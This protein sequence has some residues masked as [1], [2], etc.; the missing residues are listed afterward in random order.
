M[1][2]KAQRDGH[3]AVRC[4]ETF[5]RDMVRRRHA[6]RQLCTAWDVG[7]LGQSLAKSIAIFPRQLRNRQT[8]EIN[9]ILLYPL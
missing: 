8:K 1:R 2:G 7:H 5:T 3:P 6:P 9:V 4:I